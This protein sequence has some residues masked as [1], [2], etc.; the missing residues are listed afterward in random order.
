GREVAVLVEDAVVRQEAL[1]V[2][3]ADLAAGEDEAGVVEVRVEV[4]SADER[5][6]PVRLS[7]ELLDR[8]LRRP[9][10]PRP[11]EQVLVRVAGDGEPDEVTLIRPPPLGVP[12][13]V[14]DGHVSDG[15]AVVAEFDPAAVGLELPPAPS[16]EAAVEA[17]R[18][19]VASFFPHCFV[20]GVRR[21]PDEGL[22]I[23]PG[24]LGGGPLV[25]APWVPRP[26]TAAPE[27]V[28]CALDCPGAYACGLTERGMLVLGRMA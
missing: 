2:D 26:D 22:H 10:E 20:C 19:D 8:P 6:D 4:R 12:L 27:F 3:A 11:Q 28:W 9:D 7:R 17:Q 24:P 15:E 13:R 21:A 5:R 14:T 1:A 16:W 25:A 18:P 23:H